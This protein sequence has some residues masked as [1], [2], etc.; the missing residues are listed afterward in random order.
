LVNNSSN[1]SI[2]SQYPQQQSSPSLNPSGSLHF[3]KPN[4]LL[5]GNS[6]SNS[7]S[8]SNQVNIKEQFSTQLKKYL[9]E[10]YEHEN[11]QI[12][13]LSAQQKKLDEHASSLNTL[14][15]QVK[16]E[17]SQLVERKTALTQRVEFLEQFVE[18]NQSTETL[19]VN[20]VVLCSDLWSEQ[21]MEATA[22]DFAIADVMLELDKGL[23]DES[24]DLGSYL[25]QLR[26]LSRD[27]FMKRALAKKVYDTQTQQVA[28][29]NQQKPPF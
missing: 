24:L 27:Q 10:I 25:K 23:E 2:V 4:P 21:C 9:Q 26:K 17:H 3:G 14:K 28:S 7:N 1:P 6:N 11:T 22:H 16:K 5:N 12:N 20:K 18:K 13:H 29:A 8:N 15:E 19:D